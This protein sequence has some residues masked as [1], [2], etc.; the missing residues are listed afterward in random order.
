MVKLMLACILMALSPQAPAA[1]AERFACNMG[2]LTKGERAR[3]GTLAETLLV[4]VCEQRELPSG[5]AFR[6]PP[7]KLVTAAQWISL[8]RKCCPFFT[9]ELNQARDQGPLWLRIT[10]PQGV[11]EFIR[12]E[13]HLDQ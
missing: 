4:A 12:G 3:Y 11:K 13:F 7:G 2:A 1:G 9:F 10:G 6:L 8:E 5:Y